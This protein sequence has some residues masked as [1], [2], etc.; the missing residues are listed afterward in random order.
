MCLFKSSN[1]VCT[2]TGHECDVPQRLEGREDDSAPSE[3]ERRGRRPRCA[4]RVPSKM[5]SLR[6]VSQPLQ[7][8]RCRTWQE[9]SHQLAEKGRRGYS[10]SLPHS[11]IRDLERQNQHVQDHVTIKQFTSFMLRILFQVKDECI[12]IDNF[13]ILSD[14][15]SGQ[16]IVT[17]DHDTLQGDGK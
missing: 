13:D 10:M 17:R 11:S 1:I 16:R 2:V 6:T 12:A 5:V 8:C 9:G 14:V 15:D 4:A 3:R 7:S